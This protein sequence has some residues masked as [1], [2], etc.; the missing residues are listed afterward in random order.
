MSSE[1]IASV[2]TEIAS[3]MDRAWQASIGYF[4]AVGASL[5]VVSSDALAD[6]PKTV[7]MERSELLALLALAANPLYLSALLA[8]LFATLKRG[9]FILRMSDDRGGTEVKWERF[10][11]G[12]R[13]APMSRFAWNID[14][15]Y[16]VPTAVVIAVTSI[17][18]AWTCLT[19]RSTDVVVLGTAGLILHSVPVY[20]AFHLAKL[21]AE[22]EREANG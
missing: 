19:S 7:G 4:A 14:N 8:C 11:R 20:M 18:A 9:L 5:A 16:A 3:F 1:S 17:W 12:H 10:V 22:C 13:S 6:L 21:N 15:Y 2:K